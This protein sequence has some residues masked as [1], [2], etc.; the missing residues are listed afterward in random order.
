[1]LGL[2]N[3][4]PDEY[5]MFSHDLQSSSLTKNTNPYF[6]FTP[7]IN[8]LSKAKRKPCL[9]TTKTNKNRQQPAKKNQ[10]PTKI[11]QKAAKNQQ[12]SG[13]APRHV[14][15]RPLSGS[16][17]GPPHLWGL[18]LWDGLSDWWMVF[19]NPQSSMG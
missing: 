7:K 17:I 2:T 11:S 1:M 9:E 15:R 8:K 12:L 14:T 16:S 13:A 4:A 18:S 6:F 5:R 19:F 10:K 3:R